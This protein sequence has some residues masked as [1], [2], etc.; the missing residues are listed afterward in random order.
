M[1]T[2]GHRCKSR[3]WKQRKSQCT[4]SNLQEWTMHCCGQKRNLMSCTSLRCRPE[5]KRSI[6]GEYEN[7]SPCPRRSYQ[8]VLRSFLSIPKGWFPLSRN[9]YVRTFVKFTFANKIEAMYE[10]SHV[11]VK[12][13]L[14]STSRLSSTLYILPPFYLR[15][16]RIYVR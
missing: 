16:Y 13:E 7:I 8:L 12:V 11:S 4:K 14:R 2:S 3:V 10:R 15:D 1:S 9:F 6:R 5:A